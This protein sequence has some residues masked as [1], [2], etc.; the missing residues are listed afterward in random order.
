MPA[1]RDGLIRRTLLPVALTL[2]AGA[3]S[4]QAF[5]ALP[6]GGLSIG[7]SHVDSDRTVYPCGF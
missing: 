3:A 7:K 1:I 5:T 2:C 4:A 6:N